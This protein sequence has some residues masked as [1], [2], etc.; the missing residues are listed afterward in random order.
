[1]IWGVLVQNFQKV[2]HLYSFT[3]CSDVHNRQ[4]RHVNDL[5]LEK[6]KAYS[7]HIYLIQLYD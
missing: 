4:T 6:E 5:N 1:M 7:D 3:K 2:I